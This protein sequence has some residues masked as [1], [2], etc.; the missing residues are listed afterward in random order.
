MAAC[1]L[2]RGSVHLA[3]LHGPPS[4]LPDSHGRPPSCPSPWRRRPS[5]PLHGAVHLAASPSFE[6]QP[7]K[8]ARQQQRGGEGRESKDERIGELLCDELRSRGRGQPRRGGTGHQSLRR[9]ASPRRTRSRRRRVPSRIKP[10]RNR[11]PLRVDEGQAE[12]VETDS[13]RGD[14][15][16]AAGRLQLA[17]PGP[18]ELAL[19]LE[20]RVESLPSDRVIMSMTAPGRTSPKAIP[21]RLAARAVGRRK[22]LPRGGIEYLRGAGAPARRPR[23]RTSPTNRRGDYEGSWD[24]RERPSFFSRLR[25]VLGWSPRTAAA[26]R[27]PSMTHR[28]CRRTRGYGP[29]PPLPGT[30][31]RAADGFRSGEAEDVG[32]DVEHRGRSRGS[33]RRSR[34]FSSSRTLPGHG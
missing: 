23:L 21:C 6:E 10:A 30:R 29:A 20:V 24:D 27:G 11:G 3:L 19:E 14:P 31:G 32:I 9:E 22:S 4:I 15:G 5:C 7:G 33:R 12:E 26:P 17:D 25:R 18:E 28:V 8:A 1:P 34:T 16:A 2:L 13:V